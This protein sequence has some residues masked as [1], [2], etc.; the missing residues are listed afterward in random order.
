MLKNAKRTEHGHCVRPILILLAALMYYYYLVIQFNS[1]SRHSAFF[2]L[3]A[4]RNSVSP[5]TKGVQYI[6]VT[7]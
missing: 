6:R 3:L 4:P 2:V 5:H 1:Q 7:T